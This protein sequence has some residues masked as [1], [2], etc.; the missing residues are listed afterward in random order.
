MQ[1]FKPHLCLWS[2][3]KNKWE[4]FHLGKKKEKALAQMF[5][6]AMTLAF[7]GFNGTG[8]FCTY[9]TILVHNKSII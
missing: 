6:Y 1:S 4:C 7:I 5:K 2:L 8:V 3:K 9:E